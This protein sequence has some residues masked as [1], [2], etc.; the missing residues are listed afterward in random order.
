ML[1]GV[2]EYYFVLD[3]ATSESLS[4]A[5]CTVL[6]DSIFLRTVTVT[7]ATTLPEV[8]WNSCDTCEFSTGV[9]MVNQIESTMYPNPADAIVYINMD[10][11]GAVLEMLDITG[12]V[13]FS[14]VLTAGNNAVPTAKFSQ[15]MY[16]LFVRNGSAVN[17]HL[18]EIIH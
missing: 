10:E 18:L 8:C 17:R 14:S 4:D 5:P 7:E 1:A 3:Y 12:S 15:G 9:S 16:V 2:Y 13:V 6:A 11:E